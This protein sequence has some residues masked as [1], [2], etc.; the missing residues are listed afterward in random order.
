MKI[1][2]NKI[3][4]FG[5]HYVA[6]NLFGVVFAKCGLSRQELNH[7]YIHTLQQR[8]LLFVGFYIIYI[9]EWLVRLIQYRNAFKAYRNISFEREA[10]DKMK[11]LNYAQKRKFFAWRKYI[12][13]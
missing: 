3:I 2:R 1:F 13:T 8:E 4:P 7:E 9:I 5:K 10:Y 11:D 6:I 12:L